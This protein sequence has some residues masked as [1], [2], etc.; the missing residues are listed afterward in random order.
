MVYKISLAL[1]LL[2]IGLLSCN[3]KR[4]KI[5]DKPNVL[6]IAIDDMNGNINLLDTTYHIRTPNLERIAERGILF[7]NAFCNSPACNPSRASILSG[8]YPSSTGI[9]GNQT[10]WRAAIPHA[11]TLPEYFKQNGY[12]VIGAGKIYHHQMNHAFHDDDAF[13]EF[14][15]LPPYPDEPPPEKLNGLPVWIG[16][17][18]DG[19]PTSIPFDWGARVYDKDHQHPDIRS[20]DWLIKKLDSVE[21]PFFMGAGIFR[22]HMPTYVP[23]EYFDMYPIDSLVLPKLRKDDLEDLPKGALEILEKGKPFIY[24]TIRRGSPDGKDK[25]KE[26]LQA[27]YASC[28]FA[29]AQIGRLLNALNKS[30]HAENTIVVIWSD[31]GYHLGEKQHWEKFVL[32]DKAARIPM[33]IA[34]P[35]IRKGGRVS[36]PVSLID[37]YPT[38]NEL[39]GLPEKNDLEG[40]SLVKLMNGEKT[41]H[42]PVR[43]TYGYKNHA[44]RSQQWKYIRYHDGTE[45]LYNIKEDPH[46]WENLAEISSYDRI[47]DSLTHYLPTRNK[48]P[49]PDIVIP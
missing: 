41:D 22:P 40:N 21:S 45:E 15:K 37:I 49:V 31:H 20:V 26:A 1:T 33:I 29:D 18:R 4:G 23:Q 27:Y 43:L 13:D 17:D 3:D 48:L 11:I 42:P 8:L 5:D 9:Y 34:G 7:T 12:R 6:F 14:L 36:I 28:T 24:N 35:G 46:E 44:V 16:G 32:W 39:S 19:T 25:Y 47:K 38:L 10:D 30:K 2:G